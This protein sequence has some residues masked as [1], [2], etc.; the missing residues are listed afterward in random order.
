MRSGLDEKS[1]RIW[2]ALFSAAFILLALLLFDPK[3]DTGGDNVVYMIL[4]ESLRTGQGYADIFL[5]GAPAHIQYPFGLPVLLSLVFGFAGGISVTGA[6]VLVMLFGVG[7]MVFCLLLYGRVLGRQ[8]RWAMAAVV[9][10]PMFATAAHRV[11]T[12]IPFLCV[13]LGALYF[14][15]RGEQE[16]SEWSWWAGTVLAV[17]G[18][19]LRTAGIA[20][21][22]AVVVHLLVKRRFWNFAGLAAL[23]LALFVPWQ[24]RNTMAGAGPSYL[25]YLLAKDP[26]VA[27]FGRIDVGD[28]AVRIGTNLMRFVFE[29]VPMAFLAVL[30]KGLI[31][32]AV[33]LV[34]L[35]LLKT[36]FWGRFGHWTVLAP[37]GV[38]GFLV[39][40]AW[41]EVW[42]GERFALPLI[43][44]LA[45]YVF[46]GVDKLGRRLRLKRAVP[47]AAAAVVALNLV[48]VGIRAAEAIPDWTR[49][50]RG[51]RYAGYSP[52]WRRYMQAAEWLRNSVAKDRVVLA[53]KPE[54]VFLESGLRSFCYPF[55]NDRARV[56]AAVDSSDYVVIE[57]FTWTETAKHFLVPV[58]HQKPQAYRTVHTTG[59]P[60]VFVLE[61][62]R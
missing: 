34:L 38:L 20:L 15:V 32:W 30:G 1:S 5:P 50:A 22:V 13:S 45:V 2:V 48:A 60:E 19:L 52:G 49:Y 57:D 4:A 23:F 24:V 62:L 14:L 43:P 51:D 35:V 16:D 56:Q 61:V 7:A 10:M 39:L 31:A 3:P 53:R 25:D 47:V 9:S 55:T 41:P 18:T 36:G 21:V 54:F 33:G 12:E 42:T 46:I 17:A 8:A 27:D 29:V 59:P 58:L 11:L 6:K 37:Y 28:F 26:Y 40:L 44:V